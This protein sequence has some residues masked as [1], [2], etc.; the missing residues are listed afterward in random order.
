[1][2]DSID[3]VDAE[4]GS[5]EKDEDET[6]GH[7]EEEL[8]DQDQ[9]EEDGGVDGMMPLLPLL[10]LLPPGLL[11]LLL[12]DAADEGESGANDDTSLVVR[13]LKPCARALSSALHHTS[14]WRPSVAIA[15]ADGGDEYSLIRA[16]P[17]PRSPTLAL[18][19]ALSKSLATRSR[20]SI[21][22]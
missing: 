3:D 17:A 10:L 18:P 5:D 6:E 16:L 9:G 12:I 4:E 22:Y 15:T 19:V 20:S 8:A 1:M 14:S 2:G 7:Q 21:A 11:L 13:L